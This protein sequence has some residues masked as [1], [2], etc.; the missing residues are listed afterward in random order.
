M[1]VAVAEAWSRSAMHSSRQRLASSSSPPCASKPPR[2]TSATASANQSRSARAAEIAV[3]AT[4]MASAARPS[5]RSVAASAVPARAAV[6][7]APPPTAMC[8]A[9]GKTDAISA[10]PATHARRFASAPKASAA[11]A[12]VSVRP[13]AR[14]SARSACANRAWRHASVRSA[15]ARCA[16]GRGLAAADEAANAKSRRQ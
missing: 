9:G 12:C 6:N 3:L 14:T 8:V 1:A 13:P 7:L 16:G 4:W 5:A 11:R 2:S 10:T 15:A